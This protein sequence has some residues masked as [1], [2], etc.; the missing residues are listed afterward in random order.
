MICFLCEYLCII[1]RTLTFASDPFIFFADLV[2]RIRKFES[3]NAAQIMRDHIQTAEIVDSHIDQ[4]L[5][6]KEKVVNCNSAASLSS[7]DLETVDSHLIDAI[8]G[9]K[10]TEKSLKNKMNKSKKKVT[11]GNS[12]EG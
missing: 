11:R 1:F 10:E 2:G 7:T 4:S 12:T 6:S 3:N 8:S 5:N 9:K